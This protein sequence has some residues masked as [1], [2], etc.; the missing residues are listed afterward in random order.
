MPELP[1]VETTVRGLARLLEGE[2]I[3]RV[4]AR[5]ADLRRPFPPFLVQALTGSTQPLTLRPRTSASALISDARA[6]SSLI[7]SCALHSC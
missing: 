1:E 5:R 7:V 3:I 6:S 4:E 2:R